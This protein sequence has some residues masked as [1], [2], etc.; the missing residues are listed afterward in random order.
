MSDDEFQWSSAEDVDL[1]HLEA[2]ATAK[3]K[4]CNVDNRSS[5]KRARVH[6]QVLT[7]A[8]K[9]LQE[10]F[11]LEN[12]R[13]KQAAAIDRLLRGGNSAVVFP[14]VPAVTFKEL[15]RLN[16]ARSAYESGI[17][18]VVSP[19]IALMKDQVDF[20]NKRGV[21]AAVLDS[22]KS[23]EEYLEIAASM[24][25]GTIDIVY[26]APERLNNEGFVASMAHV[27]GGVRLLAVDEA[28]CISEWGHAFRPDYLK[29]ARFAQ[30]IR[31]ERV[32]CLTA[33]ATSAVT[34]DICKAFNIPDEGIFRTTT[35]RPNLKLLAQS[36]TTK[37]Q[38]YQHLC[39]FLKAQPG[40]TIVYV[41]LQKQTVDLAQK[42]SREGFSTRSFH[43]GMKSREKSDCQDAFMASDKLIIVATIAFGMGID[44]ANIRNVIHYDLP[45]SLEGYSQEIGRA[46]RDGLL[47]H[48]V[49]YLCSEDL[50]LR[51][52]FVRGDL[53]SKE[54][55]SKL[56]REVF[57]SPLI[58]G[59][60]ETNIFQQ[61]KQYDI[62]PTVLGNIYAQLEL[63]FE[64]LRATTPKYT[65]YTFKHIQP[66]DYDKSPAAEAIRKH[67]KKASVWTT[68]DMDAALKAGTVS[69]AEVVAKLNHWNDSGYIELKAA[70]VVN[71]YRVLK[72]S[73]A[74]AHEQQAIIDLLYK[75]LEA[76]ELQ[77]LDRMNQVTRLV[78]GSRCLARCLAEHFGDSLPDEAKECGQCTWCETHLVV[79]SVTPAQAIWDPQAFS[80]IV[81]AVPDR[82]DPRYLA[83][84]AFGISSPRITSN[85][86]NMHRV[87]GSMGH[88]DFEVRPA[89]LNSKKEACSL[90]V[91]R[92]LQAFQEVCE[93]ADSKQIM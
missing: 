60:I 87:F 54:A 47:S 9:I 37:A 48:C 78:T 18:I 38:A 55:V 23:R 52:S 72:P 68:L 92:L 58:N 41:T 21:S 69:R 65:S 40:S 74:T 25:N 2:V 26:C 10:H 89:T 53:P 33:T 20:L 4:I 73:P 36:N 35:Y 28:H 75:E 24:R 93:K 27:R 6:S 14:T 82:D 8:T 15:D 44:K 19:L 43:A 30:E 80:A 51:E 77:D 76:R 39:R 66:S 59:M 32:V 3:R 22:T 11:G 90:K 85:K 64:L 57:D 50:L 42:L 88:H 81:E 49:L 7:I 46:G 61:S 29:V 13:L 5:A 79:S 17:T 16:D 45:R 83:R 86:L 67:S 71:I 84:V 62:R 31:A 63:R 12:F 1:L 34:S 56:L 91:Q 70:G